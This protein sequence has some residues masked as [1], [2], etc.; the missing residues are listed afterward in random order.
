MFRAPATLTLIQ[1]H[2]FLSHPQSTPLHT[3]STPTL[4]THDYTPNPNNSRALLSSKPTLTIIPHQKQNVLPP[5][6]PHPRPE[7]LQPLD[8]DLQIL[9]QI[10]RSAHHYLAQRSL[11]RR[12]LALRLHP[13]ITGGAFPGQEGR[14]EPRAVVL[15]V[16]EQ[17]G[18]AVRVLPLGRGREG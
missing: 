8:S 11:L 2:D 16:P 7:P 13:A 10:P 3:S 12:R 14:E 9:Q 6:P 17:R 5:R 15:H 18:E 1:P 4:S